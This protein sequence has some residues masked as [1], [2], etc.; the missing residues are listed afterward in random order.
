MKFNLKNTW[1]FA[2]NYVSKIG[3]SHFIQ[4]NLPQAWTHLERDFLNTALP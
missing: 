4:K 2:A 3:V 1:N